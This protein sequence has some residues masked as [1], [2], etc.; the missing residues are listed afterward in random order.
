MG[1][2]KFGRSPLLELFNDFFDLVVH[3]A[4]ER[5]SRDNAENNRGR[6]K[7]CDRLRLISYMDVV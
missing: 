2:L 1:Y 6:I 5:G 7:D 3:P 4:K